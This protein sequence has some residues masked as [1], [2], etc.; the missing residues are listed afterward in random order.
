MTAG[1]LTGDILLGHPEEFI[2]GTN[3]KN[4]TFWI[5]IFESCLISL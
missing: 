3:I 1:E 2:T 5:L 4:V